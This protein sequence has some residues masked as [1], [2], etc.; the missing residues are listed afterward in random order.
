MS[1]SRSC[2][3]FYANGSAC[4]VPTTYH[5]GWCR[6]CDGFTTSTPERSGRTP[7]P[8][9]FGEIRAVSDIPVRPN[10]VAEIVCVHRA[11]LNQFRDRH[12][13]TSYGEAD[14]QIRRLLYDL[15][16]HPADAKATR[17]VSGQWALTSVRPYGFSVLLT[18][19]GKAV[20][21]YS[22][23][24][25]ERTYA[26][27]KAGVRTRTGT[28]NSARPGRVG[29]G[30]AQRVRDG[31]VPEDTAR[32]A[33]LEKGEKVAAAFERHLRRAL[34]KREPADT[35]GEVQGD[36]LR[37]IVTMDPDGTEAAGQPRCGTGGGTTP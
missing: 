21:G 34:A 6:E 14:T 15:L 13:G 36:E 37:E 25:A 8:Y 16:R 9:R 33:A 18:S 4:G 5:D 2:R 22:T 12:P 17:S 24:H 3:R 11:P 20:T 31:L 29:K 35:A 7:P 30:L 1:T 28:P 19:D 26:Q 27:V 10:D 32:A 23:K